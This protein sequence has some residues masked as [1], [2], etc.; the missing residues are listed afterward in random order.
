MWHLKPP[1]WPPLDPAEPLCSGL[2]AA[3]APRALNCIS[4]ALRPPRVTSEDGSGLPSPATSPFDVVAAQ[5]G[6]LRGRGSSPCHEVLGRP[7]QIPIP[8][9]PALGPDPTWRGPG[10]PCPEL[11]AGSNCLFQ[12]LGLQAALS[13]WPLPLI[14]ASVFS[15]LFL[16]VCVSS[17]PL[18]T[19]PWDLGPPGQSRMVLCQDA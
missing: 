6:W 19:L 11:R 2:W 1:E 18:R 16:S 15:W 7:E 4:T 13:S 10:P 5:A 9:V 12:L 17:V 3:W 14:S 8:F